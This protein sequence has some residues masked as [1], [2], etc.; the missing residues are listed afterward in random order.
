[1]NKDEM[2]LRPFHMGSGLYETNFFHCVASAEW[3]LLFWGN[4]LQCCFICSGCALVVSNETPWWSSDACV[5][6]SQQK[7]TNWNE[8]TTENLSY[9]PFCLRNLPHLT[10]RSDPTH[11]R[12]LTHPQPDLLTNKLWP[13]KII[14][15]KSS[16]RWDLLMTL[17]EF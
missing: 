2:N 4:I 1:M 12:R 7:M 13:K 3:R 15:I 5:T 11:W 10:D 17:N 9:L 8:V 16:T 14:S 6:R